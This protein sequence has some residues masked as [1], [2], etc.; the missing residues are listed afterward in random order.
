MES[1]QSLHK[2]LRQKAR[3]RSL[4]RWA[5]P[6]LRFF[7]LAG[8][9]CGGVFTAWAIFA[10]IPA[11]DTIENRIVGESTKIYDRTGEVLLY[12]VHGSMRRT[13]IPFNDI[14]PYIRDATVAIEDD[15]FYEHNGFRPMAFLRA[16]L[17]NLGLKEGFRGQ[18]GSTI[19]QQVVKNTLLTQDKTIIRKLKEIVLAIK[20]ERIATKEE[21]LNIY[22]NETTYG[23]TIYGVEEASQ[24]FFGKHAKDVT[25][26]EAAYLSALPQAPT[27]YSPYGNHTD[28]LEARK[29]LVLARMKSGGSITEEQYDGATAEHVQFR[30]ELESGIKAPHFVFYIREYLEEKYGA[31]AVANEGL[32]VITTL[33]WELQQE[34]EKIVR[35]RALANEK[36]FNAENAG[37]VAL[38]PKTGQI[39]AMV[40]SRGF[41][42]E[43]I[44]GQVN[45]T[46]MRRQPGSSFKP[47][48][49]A[50]AFEKG[51]TPETIVFDVQT[52]FSTS[53]SA[54]DVTNSE[55]PCYSPG[56]YDHKFRGPVSLRN[57]LA[58][59]LNIP[60]V[61]TLYLAG[62]PDSIETARDMGITTLTDASRYGLTLVLGG[63]EVTLLEMTDA[64]GVF[65]NDGLRNAPTGILSIEDNR[66]NVLEQYE[67]QESRALDPQISRQITDILSDNTA[68]TPLYGPNSPLY[69]PGKDVA[70]KTG[71]TNDN[72]DAW[73]LGYSTSI[74]A[75]AWAGNNIPESMNQIS[76]LIVTPMWR[77][78]M[79]I[80]LEKYPPGEF[81]PPSPDPERDSLPSVL[82]GEWNT[83]PSLG[84]HEI[85]YWVNKDNPRSGGRP[86]FSDSQINH[87]DYAVSLWAQQAVGST[88]PGVA[89]F[90]ISSPQAGSQ[91]SLSEPF[92]AS[93]NF[94]PSL[95]IRNVTYYLNT[96]FVGVSAQPPYVIAVQPRQSGQQTLRAVAETN[97]RNIETQI[98]FSVQ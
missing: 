98:S 23:G 73:V 64:Y 67:K 52:Q 40:G 9:A 58:Q 7:I 57:A 85:L 96:Q 56:N 39:L 94:Q 89:G 92:D 38:D 75:G 24:Y 35:E 80:A 2:Q 76:G 93:V 62:I 72:K 41:L 1:E 26:A 37:L 6:T 54:T 51:Y 70:A 33:D 25:L 55:P 45:V 36:Q 87:W 20:L 12:D 84:V 68:R 19:T 60:A 86:D 31:D 34:A 49:Y 14:S 81:T 46:V 90:S 30:E 11:V 48:V 10:S 21:I 32:K 4:P 88:T 43:D 78:F 79:D 29:N 66:D 74:V 53:C 95:G 42:D 8:I 82:R 18:G 65:A 16:V 77:Q 97:N 47:F 59:S 83:N 5:R 71:T 22:L 27:R 69:F 63:G 17:V 44:D 15:S 3:G 61:K 50:T 91:L 28:E 13:E